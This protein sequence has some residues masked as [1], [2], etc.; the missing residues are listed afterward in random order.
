MFTKMAPGFPFQTTFFLLWTAGDVPYVRRS[1]AGMA[2]QCTSENGVVGQLLVRTLFWSKLRQRPLPRLQL[3][4]HLSPVSLNQDLLILPP[5][6]PQQLHHSVHPHCQHQHP[7]LVCMG[8]LLVNYNGAIDLTY[9]KW[10][11]SPVPAPFQ[12][13]Y[14]HIGSRASSVFVSLQKARTI[15]PSHFEFY[16]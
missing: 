4:L 12:V 3:W 10:L 13:N 6:P 1:S 15:Q 14:D 8:L 11:A 5:L 7:L 16:S 9:T 2:S